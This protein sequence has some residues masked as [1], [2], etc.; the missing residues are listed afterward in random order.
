LE[1]VLRLIDIRA[2]AYVQ[3]VT[4]ME[5]Q[6]AFMTVLNEFGRQAWLDLTGRPIEVLQPFLRIP[7]NTPQYSLG[8]AHL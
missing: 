5:S 2:A 3:L 7:A 6:E 4:D 1:T 8:L